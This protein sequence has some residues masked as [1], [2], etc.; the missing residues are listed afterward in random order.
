VQLWSL[1]LPEQPRLLAS[2]SEDRKKTVVCGLLALRNLLFIRGTLAKKHTE[3]SARCTR[4]ER[5][6]NSKLAA[7]V[8]CSG[9]TPRQNN[10]K[11]PKPPNKPQE[12][13]GGC[14]RGFGASGASRY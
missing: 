8:E 14:Y 13:T 9:R 1:S 2:S 5:G 11:E 6:A 12:Q 3:S 4:Y 10:G 7:C